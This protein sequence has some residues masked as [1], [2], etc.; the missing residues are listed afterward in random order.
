M[1]QKA[2][3]AVEK[4]RPK[5]VQVLQFR[6]SSEESGIR[7]PAAIQYALVSIVN[8]A[9]QKR[10]SNLDNGVQ[11]DTT[12]VRSRDA[13]VS[14]PFNNMEPSDKWQQPLTT[15]FGTVFLWSN[16]LWSRFLLA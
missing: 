5:D 7:L 16:A 10:E 13:A 14:I 6:K 9:A 1:R 12:F 8:Q 4:E 11:K 2:K 15:R 3:V